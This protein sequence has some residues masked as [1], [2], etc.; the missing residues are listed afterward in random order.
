MATFLAQ[1]LEQYPALSIEQL[2]DTEVDAIIILS[3][4]QNQYAPEFGEPVSGE[5]Q[6]VRIRYGAFLQ[7][8]TGL[9]VLVSGGSV[10]G[11]E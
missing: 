9:P 6:L 3:A 10:R 5:E 7:K 1:S 4:R 2:G 11:D 8:E